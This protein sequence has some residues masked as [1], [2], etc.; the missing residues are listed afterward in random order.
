MLQTSQQMLQNN[1]P[2][3][4][5]QAQV[6]IVAVPAIQSLVA[7]DYNEKLCQLPEFTKQNTLF[8]GTYLLSFRNKTRSMGL[9]NVPGSRVL[10]I[11]LTPRYWPG[12][13][14]RARFLFACTGNLKLQWALRND[15]HGITLLFTGHV[16]EP[17]VTLFYTTTS[18][19]HLPL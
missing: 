9:A 1:T 7:T 16:V 6:S 8:I 15:T 17:F 19:P 2:H 11:L 13:G 3:Y 12:V 10:R 18:W 4:K 14:V 5:I